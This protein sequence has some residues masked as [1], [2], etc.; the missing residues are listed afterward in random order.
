[1]LAALAR[2]A[3]NAP[4]RA[5]T[6]AAFRAATQ[7]TVDLRGGARRLGR[8]DRS[9]YIMIAEHVA[10]ADDHG[11]RESLEQ[12]FKN[13]HTWRR[14]ALIEIKCQPAGPAACAAVELRLH[15]SVVNCA[16][17]RRQ[18]SRSIHVHC[19]GQDSDSARRGTVSTRAGSSQR[20][21][22]DLQKGS[23]G[24]TK[25]LLGSMLAF[26]VVSVLALSAATPTL[27]Q[28][29]QRQRT[30]A[31][32]QGSNAGP[33]D[34]TFGQATPRVPSRGAAAHQCW[35]PTND[36]MGVGYW[37]DCSAKGSRPTK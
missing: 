29:Q 5:R 2:L 6:A 25:R 11:G 10:G 36:D 35:I 30:P 33:Q 15:K 8:S 21:T 1:M 27:G 20:A 14:L 32:E 18:R 34:E 23:N 17:P 19:A 4:D 16:L 37:G 3:D 7:A 24:M 9:A 22:Q 12:L 28:A 26:G 13:S 31:Q